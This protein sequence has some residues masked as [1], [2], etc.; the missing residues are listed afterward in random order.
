MPWTYSHRIELGAPEHQ[1][2]H[3]LTVHALWTGTKR[4]VQKTV[5]KGKGKKR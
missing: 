1:L 5:K 2:P 4:K 3:A